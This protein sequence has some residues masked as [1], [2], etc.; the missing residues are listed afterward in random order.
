MPKATPIKA[1]VDAL[2]ATIKSAAGSPS[3]ATIAQIPGQVSAVVSA[4]NS[5]QSATKS[6]CS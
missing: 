2:S 1:S 5:F 6:K 3:A 4:V